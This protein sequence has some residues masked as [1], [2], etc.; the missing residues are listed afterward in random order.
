M[1]DV[2]YA[3][4]IG[5]D[6]IV[7]GD[8][9]YGEGF[10]DD[11]E[12]GDTY[13]PGQL[14]ALRA[15]RAGAAAGAA[16]WDDLPAAHG[17]AIAFDLLVL[18]GLLLLG[19]AAAAGPRGHGARAGARLRLGGLPVH[20]VRARDELERLA[21]GARLR[22]RAAG[23]HASAGAARGALGAAWRWGS[24]PRRSSRR[25]RW[26]RCSRA[27][28]PLV[29]RRAR[30]SLT[31]WRSRCCRSCPTAACAS[32]TTARSATRRARPSPFSVWG[33]VESLGWL[34]TVVK[35]AAVG[36][37]AARGLR[38]A[39]AGPRQVAAL[40]AAVLIA[41]Q[42]T[43]THWF[44]LY[45]VW[46]VPFVLVALFAAHR[47]QPGARAA[48]AGAAERELW[49]REARRGS[50]RWPAG[51]SAGPLTLWVVPWSDERVN[52]LFVY[53]GVRRARAR[54]RRCP[55]ATSFFE[56]PPLAAPAIALPGLAGTG[57]EAFRLAFAGLDPAAGGAAV[58]LL[59]GAPGA[60]T[61]GDARRAH[62]RGGADAAA[63]RR[64]GAHA[65]RPRAGG[66]HARRRCCCCARDRP[67][68]AWRSS[69]WAAM[70]K[71]FPLVAAP[72]ALA[73]LVRGGLRARG[74]AAAAGVRGACVVVGLAALAVSPAG[75]ADAVELPLRA[76]RPGRE[77][78]RPG[79]PRARRGRRWAR[80]ASVSSHR[81]DGLE[82]PAGD[83]AGVALLVLLAA[84][85]SPADCGGAGRRRERDLVLGG[86]R[87]R[88]WPSPRSARCSRRSS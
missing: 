77:P 35:V 60:R 84:A 3:G 13:G 58:V 21:G 61:G 71:G 87:G 56:Y 18:G 73:W 9:L 30:C 43:A 66:A 23:A 19:P 88:R 82:H 45:V 76:S 52:D 49:P 39:A 17:A 48:G 42:L 37:G 11:V 41:V 36:A 78:A 72:V 40:G 31:L 10:S 86:A 8:E 74:L 68:R 27:G 33:Q 46:F 12:R 57:E 1:I 67:G 70:T 47:A 79:A 7:D 54:R 44:Y 81:S 83:G 53:R 5:A 51:R 4:V 80:R 25:W 64:D 34:Q 38:A 2:G 50:S 16:R 15:V 59:C 55:T 22:R 28:A 20:G 65:L 85:W 26:R 75:A 63:L 32:S 29:V 14:P 24:A 62:A 69:A 6:R